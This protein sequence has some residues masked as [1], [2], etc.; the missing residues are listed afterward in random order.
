MCHQEG[1]KERSKE[2]Q[3]FYVRYFKYVEHFMSKTNN[4]IGL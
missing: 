1:K 2:H 4:Q 3:L